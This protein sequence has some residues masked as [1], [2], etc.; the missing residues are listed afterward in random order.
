MITNFLLFALKFCE[1][2]LK[3]LANNRGIVK[4]VDLLSRS[5]FVTKITSEVPLKKP[6][7]PL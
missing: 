5:N 6:S 1:N 4:F 7:L 3:N 2:K